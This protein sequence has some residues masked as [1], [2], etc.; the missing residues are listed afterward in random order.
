MFNANLFEAIPGDEPDTEEMSLDQLEVGGALMARVHEASVGYSDVARPDES[1]LIAWA[2]EVVP[3]SL[4]KELDAVESRMSQLAKD[5]NSY[6]LIHYDM[7]NIRW[8]DG[9][10]SG[11]FDFDDCHYNWFEADIVSAVVGLYDKNID[12]LDPFP[13]FRRL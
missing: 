5:E 12:Q 2:R 6:G 3:T 13:V 11:I 4:H 9:R 10:V 8:V 7:D 1:G